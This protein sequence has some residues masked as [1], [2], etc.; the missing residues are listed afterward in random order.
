MNQIPVIHPAWHGEPASP[1]SAPMWLKLL[2]TDPEISLILN[3]DLSRGLL[4]LAI[5]RKKLSNSGEKHAGKR[6]KTRVTSAAY[7]RLS[8]VRPRGGQVDGVPPCGRSER[9]RRSAQQA[10][11]AHPSS[12]ARHPQSVSLTPHGA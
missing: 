11:P 9:G 1:S 10:G 6:Q 2:R 12:P 8:L 5:L 4:D 3:L 7:S